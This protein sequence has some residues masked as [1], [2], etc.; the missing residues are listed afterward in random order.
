M[1][2]GFD[3]MDDEIIFVENAGNSSIFEKDSD[4][5]L[6]VNQISFAQSVRRNMP[7]FIVGIY[8]LHGSEQSLNGGNGVT[9][10]I[11]GMNIF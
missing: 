11:I 7:A 3:R 2:A 10:D 8:S 9:V 1:R 4:M 6:E 5:R